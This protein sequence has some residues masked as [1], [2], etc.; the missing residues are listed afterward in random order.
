MMYI[1][2]HILS[3]IHSFKS[4]CDKVFMTFG[5][6]FK[7]E[8]CEVEVSNILDPNS[9]LITSCRSLKKDFLLCV[10]LTLATQFVHHRHP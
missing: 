9:F 3:V 8:L 10:P 1:Y 2:L 5:F 4:F 6:N 7:K